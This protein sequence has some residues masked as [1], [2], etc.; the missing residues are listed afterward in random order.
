MS[1][2]GLAIGIPQTERAIL[3]TTTPTVLLA[4]DANGNFVH[5]IYVAE[6]TGNATTIILDAFDGVTAFRLTGTRT[7]AANGD[8]WLQ[9]EQRLEAGWAIR[10]TAGAANRLHV[11]TTHSLPV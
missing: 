6:A 8:V 4:A 1:F 9:I 7:V 5:S 2:H 11:H 3:A 10:A